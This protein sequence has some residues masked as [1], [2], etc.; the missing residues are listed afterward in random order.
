MTCNVR[1]VDTEQTALY[2]WY[3]APSRF[4]ACRSSVTSL[5]ARIVTGL[6]TT[7]LRWFSSSS[8]SN[9]LVGGVTEISEL[10]PLDY[11]LVSLM[12]LASGGR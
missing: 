12:S 4:D 2:C 11:L 9:N 6:F 5:W 1:S 3:V 10:A 7:V 8:K